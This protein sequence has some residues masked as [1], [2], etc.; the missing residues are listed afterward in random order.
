MSKVS[1]K[2]DSNNARESDQVLSR[3]T[4]SGAYVG[5]ITLAKH[6]VSSQKESTGIQFT[7]KAE[8]GATA[9][10]LTIYTRNKLGEPLKGGEHISALLA[11]LR[12]R[13]IE[14]TI[15]KITEYNF[16]VGADVV[17]DATIFPELMNKPIGVIL[18]ASEREKNNGSIVTE[19]SILRFFDAKTRQ[20][21]SEILDKLPATK[22]D[23]ALLTLKD[24][25]LAQK[26]TTQ[27]NHHEQKANAY[28]PAYGDNF[29]DDIPF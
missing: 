7:F 5:E 10:Y 19:L 22:V 16:S 23:T 11:C 20:T 14:S 4:T 29:D 28:A 12:L 2:F 9:S 13:E 1:Y 21:A 17:V 15:Q 8:D 27:S 18:Q 26:H 6:I 24:K 25:K 3:I